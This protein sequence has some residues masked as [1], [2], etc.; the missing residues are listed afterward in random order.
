MTLV[1]E[2][3][4][5]R[6]VQSPIRMHAQSVHDDDAAPG[7]RRIRIKRQHLGTLRRGQ[8]HHFADDH[9]RRHF[10]RPAKLA[11]IVGNLCPGVRAHHGACDDQRA[12]QSRPDTAIDHASGPYSEIEL[13]AFRHERRKG[14][15]RL[16]R[17]PSSMTV[18]ATPH[19]VN[20]S[21]LS[22][23]PTTLRRRDRAPAGRCATL[24]RFECAI[25]NSATCH[26]SSSR[27]TPSRARFPHPTFARLSVE[28]SHALGP[29]RK[30]LRARWPM[31]AKGRS[32]RS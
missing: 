13:H 25:P 24:Q 9:L 21:W 17:W 31:A 10:L 16:P 18:H 32:T 30:S 22:T 8:P 20:I 4:A 6:A 27:R 29:M 23:S 1:G 28:A 2:P 19:R 26:A 11:R 12:T 5:Q 3:R 15:T 14:K 7:G